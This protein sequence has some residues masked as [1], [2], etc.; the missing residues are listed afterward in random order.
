M[1]NVETDVLTEMQL[2]RNFKYILMFSVVGD[3]F[4]SPWNNVGDDADVRFIR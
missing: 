3:A 1:R 2:K 4:V